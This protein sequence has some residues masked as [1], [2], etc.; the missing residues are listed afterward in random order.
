MHANAVPGSK[1]SKTLALAL[2]SG[3]PAQVDRS[4]H[5]VPGVW[6]WEGSTLLGSQEQLCPTANFGQ[7]HFRGSK[8]K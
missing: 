2:F 6:H 5:S 4:T 8:D 1:V 7:L 3:A